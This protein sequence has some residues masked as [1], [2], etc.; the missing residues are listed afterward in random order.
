MR[1]VKL[2]ADSLG[3]TRAFDLSHA[4]DLLDFEKKIEAKTWKLDDPNFTLDENGSIKPVGNS[5][6]SSKSNK[7]SRSDK[8]DK[9]A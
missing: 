6:K 2:T 8:S 5:E 4:Q 1:K 9:T 3:E 7:D